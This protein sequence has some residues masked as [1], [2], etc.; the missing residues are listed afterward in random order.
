M[1]AIFVSAAASLVLTVIAW[2][3]QLVQLP[4]LAKIGRAEFP[5]YIRA[6]R[7]RNTILMAGPMIVEAIAAIWA[8]GVVLRIALAVIWA[9]T[10]LRI[11]PLFGKLMDG[12]DEVVVA[13]LSRWNLVRS[14]LWT[15]R[16]AAF[17]TFIVMGYASHELRP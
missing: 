7:M 2:S 14:L 6:H 9:I 16:M 11:T 17:V 4:L 10:F 1:I 3:L 5:G 13:S 12:Y 15:G 8:H